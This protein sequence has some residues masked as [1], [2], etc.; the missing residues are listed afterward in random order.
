MMSVMFVILI[1]ELATQKKTR[2]TSVAHRLGFTPWA[3][4]K[5]HDDEHRVR[6]CGFKACNT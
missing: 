4:K 5:N 6:P 2:M 1:L 3:I